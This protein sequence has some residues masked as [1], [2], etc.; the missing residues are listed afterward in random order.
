MLLLSCNNSHATASR[1]IQSCFT[2]TV[3]ETELE[4]TTECQYPAVFN[5]VI[6]GVAAYADILIQQI[7][8][9]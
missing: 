5:V 2:Q 1:I 3:G 6:V 4:E 7:S 8:G 9:T